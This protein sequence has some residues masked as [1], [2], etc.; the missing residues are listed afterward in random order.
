MTGALTAGCGTASTRAPDGGGTVAGFRNNYL[1]FRYPSGWKPLQFQ[2][3]GTLHFHPMV[4]VSTQPGRNPCRQSPTGTVCGW[5]IDRLRPNG[6][7][8]V[9]ENRGYPG[10][11]LASVPGRALR[12]GGRSARSVTAR[13]GACSAIGA[14]E[15]VEVAIQRPVPENW[16]AFTACLRGPDL[17]AGEREVDALL[18]STRFLAP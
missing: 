6:V 4:Y 11:S 2:I 7:L 18:A 3:T 10:W 14:D 9:W 8:I 13:T 5:P 16:T 12:V 1:A 17:S 15:T